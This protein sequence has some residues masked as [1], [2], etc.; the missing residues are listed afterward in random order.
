MKKG[1]ATPEN[2]QLLPGHII[3]VAETEGYTVDNVK[4]DGLPYD[5]VARFDVYRHFICN[6]GIMGHFRGQWVLLKNGRIIKMP[7]ICTAAYQVIDD[8]PIN[9]AFPPK[10]TFLSTT[11]SMFV[12]GKMRSVA[13]FHHLG[14]EYIVIDNSG[15]SAQDALRYSGECVSYD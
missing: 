15:V 8:F 9:I 14:Q 7:M 6:D 10:N 13:H 1:F 2:N 5:E 3:A 12:G 11:Y 4:C